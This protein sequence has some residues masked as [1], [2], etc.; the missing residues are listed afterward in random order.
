[1]KFNGNYL[2]LAAISSIGLSA[3][4]SGSAGVSNPAVKSLSV[5]SNSNNIFP[6][7]QNGSVVTEPV[8]NSTIPLILMETDGGISICTGTLLDANTVLTAAH[9]AINMPAKKS[10]DTYSI[11]NVLKPSNIKIYLSKNPE[12][13]ISLADGGGLATLNRIANS[14]SVKEVYV[15]KYAFRSAEVL[16]NGGF[17]LNDGG[18]LNDLAI[19][20]LN[21][22]VPNNYDFPQLATTNPS[23]NAKQVIAGYGVNVGRGVKL[24]DPADGD[25][26]TLR[27]AKSLFIQSDFGGKLLD[28]GGFVKKGSQSIYT[29]I[30]QGDSGGPDFLKVKGKYILTGVHSFGD[31]S[32]CGQPNTPSTSISV[33]AYNDW[34]TGGYKTLYISNE[35]GRSG[36]DVSLQSCVVNGVRCIELLPAISNS[37]AYQYFNFNIKPANPNETMLNFKITSLKANA[38]D[39]LSFLLDSRYNVVQGSTCVFS[40]NISSAKGCNIFVKYKPLFNKKY[41]PLGLQYTYINQ[42]GSLVNGEYNISY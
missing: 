31:G 14:Y 3:C 32:E 10:G 8:L 37:A 28:V 35:S 38:Y 34:I 21:D 4:N 11:S 27:K 17:N 1:M 12:K 19:L 6:F 36:L 2:L 29:K 5:N 18:D 42:N 22:L 15:H 20:K 23:P 26:A 25:A 40:S 33:A 24:D 16:K 39:G 13:A 30:C 7:V 9:C 41:S